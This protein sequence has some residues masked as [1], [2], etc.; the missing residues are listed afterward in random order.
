M[1]DANKFIANGPSEKN[2][3]KKQSIK[4]IAQHQLTEL[5][6]ELKDFP[7]LA[8]NL[9]ER[10]R[11]QSLADLPESQ[12]ASTMTRILRIKEEINNQNGDRSGR[13]SSK[14]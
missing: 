14:F 13:S 3:P 12:Y 8:E 5:E 10:L 4:V 11:I 7:E 1:I 9:L 6:R 2:N